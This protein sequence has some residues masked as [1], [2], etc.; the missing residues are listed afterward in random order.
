[1]A[2]LGTG[3]GARSGERL[4]GCGPAVRCVATGRSSG[5]GAPAAGSGD[6]PRR[7]K[8]V[9]GGLGCRRKRP[10]HRRAARLMVEID[11]RLEDALR[12]RY[13]LERELARVG[14]AAV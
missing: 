11:S 5:P 3:D 1:M 10:G 4:G 7:S 8:D 12:D 9:S 2:R 14:M 6:L 13:I